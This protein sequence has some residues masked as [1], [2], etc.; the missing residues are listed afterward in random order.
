[1]NSTAE[2][3][4]SAEIGLFAYVLITSFSLTSGI[5]GLKA[6]QAYFLS[7]SLLSLNLVV[8]FTQE[9][10]QFP[11]RLYFLTC[12]VQI[13]FIFTTFALLKH[14]KFPSSCSSGASFAY[15]AGTTLAVSGIWGAFSPVWLLSF[16]PQIAQ[17]LLYLYELVPFH[18]EMKPLIANYSSKTGLFAYSK[19]H[20]GLIN[21]YLLISG[22]L[23]EESIAIHFFLMQ[24][25]LGLYCALVRLHVFSLL[26]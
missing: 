2:L 17:I 14:C 22:P 18:R 23:D 3:K 20:N 16:T 9:L 7:I 1:M 11:L 24:V 8:P 5:N 12:Q 19:G 21:R 6:G 13:P 10:T 15:F 26:F 25:L 4:Y